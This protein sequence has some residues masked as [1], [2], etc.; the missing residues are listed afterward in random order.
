MSVADYFGGFTVTDFNPFGWSERLQD[1]T[2]RPKRV[3]AEDWPIPT[4]ERSTCSPTPG[5]GSPTRQSFR[6][7]RTIRVFL[8]RVSEA[9]HSPIA[10]AFRRVVRSDCDA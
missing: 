1:T 4:G 5:R 8:D 2:K 6:R 10:F 7:S 3:E 9:R